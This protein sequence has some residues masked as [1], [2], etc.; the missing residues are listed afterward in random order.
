MSRLI[1]EINGP[2][3]NRATSGRA[4]QFWRNKFASSLRLIAE[5]VQAGRTEGE[6]D[7][8]DLAGSYRLEATDEAADA[9]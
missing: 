9:A 2:D 6:I 3:I 8:G 5:S 1:V 7:V 4:D